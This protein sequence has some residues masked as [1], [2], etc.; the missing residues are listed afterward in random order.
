[1]ARQP[2]EGATHMAECFWPDV[3]EETVDRAAARIRESAA[4]LSG[5]GNS[6]ELTGTILLPGDDV[7]LYLFN[8]TAAAVQETCTRAQIPFERVVES[9]WTMTTRGTSG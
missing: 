6:V 5:A 9:V 8:G 1:M 2:E 3:R 7:V 4:E